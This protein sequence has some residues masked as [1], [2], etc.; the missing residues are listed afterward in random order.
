MR[1]VI[2]FLCF[3]ILFT[4]SAREIEAQS[5]AASPIENITWQLA[6]LNGKAITV[7]SNQRR[8]FMRLNAENKG[9][10]AYAGCNTIGGDYEIKNDQ[11]KIKPGPMTMMFCEGKME[12]EQ[13]FIKALE[14]VTSWKIEEAR[15]IL[16]AG[17][18]AVAE[19]RRPVRA[20]Q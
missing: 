14:S 16:S 11:L 9:L 4:F 18:K 17:E 1:Y 2:L 12:L 5:A 19:F 7:E 6:M 13:S 3:P 10:G 20:R 15:L 8:P